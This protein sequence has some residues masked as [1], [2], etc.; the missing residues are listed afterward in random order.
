[1][2]EF[3]QAIKGILHDD[4]S[5]M[6]IVIHR[7]PDGD[8]LGSGLA[9]KAFLEKFNHSVTL[10]SPSEFPT[11]FDWMHNVD[12]ILV[13]DTDGEEVEEKIKKAR[14]V[15]CLD[16]NALDR[17]DHVG[18]IIFENNKRSVLIDH[19]I[20]PEPFAEHMLSDTGASSTCEL[21]YRIIVEAG[22]KS[23]I[24]DHIGTAL[25][26]GIL[27]DTGSFRHSTNPTVFRIAADLKEMGIDD[28]YIQDKVF[29]NNSEKQL[30]L[31]G[32]SLY[33]RM[34]ILEDGRVGLIVL[35]KEDYNNF[36][37]QRGDTEGIVNYLLT[38]PRVQ[39]AAFITQQPKL[40]KLSFRSKRNISVQAL[41]R[42]H[43]NGGGHLN[44]SGGYAFQ[45][46]AT[47]IKVFKRVVHKYLEDI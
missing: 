15:F 11:D 20:E 40:V 33:E 8:A 32:L 36:D 27:T 17:I 14:W 31:L 37:I 44:A 24:D 28:S 22:Y 34:E 43:F 25:Y 4:A 42:E 23:R 12:K 16:F 5:D 41:A 13:H 29:N 18:K 19:H 46:L 45:P 47:V 7:N 26:T 38:I 6:A 3:I 10:I 35:T 30:R 9:W 39:I 1:M 2:T 21:I